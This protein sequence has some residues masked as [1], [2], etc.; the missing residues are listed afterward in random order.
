VFT[1]PSGGPIRRGQLN[2]ILRR[3][4]EATELPPSTG[5][6]D[7]RHFYASML[8]DAGESVKVVQERLGHSSAAMT[9]N[10][11][12][13]LIPSTE[14]RSRAAVEA[15]LGASLGRGATIVRRSSSAPS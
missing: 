12:S 11:Y 9:L 2:A 1:G 15:V 4:V 6:H 14:E 5:F 7:L 13:H 3:V 10:V 8:I